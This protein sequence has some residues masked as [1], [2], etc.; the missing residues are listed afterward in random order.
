MAKSRRRAP[1]GTRVLR[2]RRFKT[3]PSDAFSP[4]DSPSFRLEK[5]AADL[6]VSAFRAAGASAGTAKL[7]K[8]AIRPGAMTLE[9]MARAR[10]ALVPEL[11]RI[12][13]R[14]FF[15]G[16]DPL[17]IVDVRPADGFVLSDTPF[18]LAITYQNGG[19]QPCVV[20][21]AVVLWAGEPFTV[22]SDLVEQQGD[23]NAVIRFD[24]ERTLPVGQAEFLVS[25]YRADGAQATFRRTVFVL[26]SNPLSLTLA[27]AGATVT[28]TWSARGDYHPENDT[29]L[30]EVQVT[31]ANGD[32]LAVSIRN[33]VNWEFWDGGVGSGTRVESGSFNLDGAISVPAHGTFRFGAWFSSPRGSGVFNTYE[34]KEDLALQITM[35]AADGRVISGQITCRVMLAF[36]VNIIKVGDF[37]SAEHTDLYNAVDQ[38]RQI[39][40]RRDITLRGVDRWI[41]NNSLAG[42]LTVL[43]SENEFR[44]M[45]E[46]WSVPNDF[47]DVYVVQ[48]F[49]WGGY[50]GFAG[51]IPGPASKGGRE[52]GV[53]VEKTGFTDASG[54]NRLNTG[55]LSQLIGHEIGHY[56]G[57]S[58]QETTNNLMRSNTGVRGPD[59]DYDQ[60]RTM[61]PHG[62]MVFL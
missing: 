37:G 60:Y 3:L 43:D 47:V 28:G 55:V 11:R 9:Q 49:N 56:L 22:E 4:F 42:G 38:M 5:L 35:T 30:T 50:N 32:G 19:H 15:P 44:D 58:H 53:A 13:H 46:D 41:I 34:R 57:L 29:F 51:D 62:Y 21:S 54:T 36:G 17:H 61:F 27:P 14:S 10:P 18:T 48:Q 45:L 26:P 23:G 20:A 16:E 24:R 2:T 1:A 31:I 59:L 6:P 39:Y 33:G 8:Q 7:L 52:D 40:E 25:L 12:R